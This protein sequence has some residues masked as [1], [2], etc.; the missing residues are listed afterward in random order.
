M[1]E[2]VSEQNQEISRPKSAKFSGCPF[3]FLFLACFRTRELK[4]NS[5]RISFAMIHYVENQ[6]IWASNKESPDAQ[7]LVC[8]NCTIQRLFRKLA[9]KKLRFCLTRAICVS[10]VIII[11]AKSSS[12]TTFP[13]DWTG[14]IGTGQSLSVG[15]KGRPV[16][17]TTQPCHNLKLS[18]GDLPWPIDP[19]NPHLSLVPLVE[20][21]GRLSSSYPSSW[22]ENIAGETPHSAM[23]NEITALVQAGFG[24]DYVTIHSAVGENGQGMVFLKKNAIQKGVNGRSYAAAL[25]ETRAITRLAKAAGKS[26]GVGAIVLTHGETDAGNKNYESELY[27]LWSDYNTDLR[28]ITGQKQKIPMILSQQNTCADRSA[29]TLAQWKIG[30]DY[31]ADFVCSGPK[32]QYPSPEGLHLTAEGYRLLGEKYG[33]VYFEKVILGR[34][35]RPLEP[36]RAKRHGNII[37]VRYHVPVPPMIWDTRMETPHSSIAEWKNGKGFEV[38]AS[39]GARVA[40]ASTAIS[41]DDVVITCV[42]DPGPGARM[43]YAMIGEKERMQKPFPGSPRWGLLRDSDPFVGAVT[44][45]SQ[46]NYA[47]AFEMP[48]P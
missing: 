12:A 40:I 25:I 26:Y 16:L 13:W 42:S 46:P 35:W 34:N 3:S 18:T 15:E 14:I 20:P 10:A 4:K 30:V 22:P 33:E 5:S 9:L 21:I 37:T 31:S 19:N 28:A 36:L 27:R 11:F 2:H 43:S 45:Q 8:Q 23:A 39:D 7:G 24:R 44:G 1:I 32:Y 48:L 6:P 38:T 17:S 47:V 29:S 41:A